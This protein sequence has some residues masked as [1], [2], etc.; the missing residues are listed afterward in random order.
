MKL[1]RR[2]YLFNR[3]RKPNSKDI[4]DKLNKLQEKIPFEE[5][6]SIL[7]QNM[8]RL[9]PQMRLKRKY[10]MDLHEPFRRFMER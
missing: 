8:D 3:I 2:I 7:L 4:L 9:Y 1:K 6:E 10:I 5:N